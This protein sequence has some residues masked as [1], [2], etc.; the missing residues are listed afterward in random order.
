M[1]ASN[2]EVLVKRIGYEAEQVHSYELIAR[3]GSELAPFTAGSHVDLY[4][5]NGMIRSYSLVNDQCERHRYVIA[6]NKDAESRGGSSFVHDTVGVGDVMTISVP[7][8]NFALCE[9]AGHSV[10]IA[11]GIG[12]TPLLSMVRRL[13]ALGRRWEL[14]YAARTRAAAAFLDE[15]GTYRSRVHLDFDDE[16]AGRVFDLA[17]IVGNAPAHTHLYCCG[18]VPMLAAFEAATAGRPAD[19]VHVEYFKARE[20]PATEGGFDVRL[21]RS[22]RTIAVEAGKTILDA[23]LDAGIAA[24]YACTEGVCG[25]CETRV[26]DGIPDHRDQFLSEEEQAANKSVMICC[27]GA[28]SRT[29][30]LDL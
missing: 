19:H 10:L 21:A 28:K 18:P 23:L 4:L 15:L 24:N 5:S 26:L 8:N 11:G 7:R 17:T 13:E 27:S 2:Q 9:E 25:T 16:R 20:A 30:V 29:L 12:I 6:V 22:N 3:T 1:N 14:F